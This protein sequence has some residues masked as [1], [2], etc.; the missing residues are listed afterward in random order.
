MSISAA[1]PADMPI[2]LARFY[3][4]FTA[5]V[6]VMPTV[7]EEGNKEENPTVVTPELLAAAMDRFQDEE[8]WY[9]YLHSL[10]VDTLE[11]SNLE[12]SLYDDE[13]L[14]PRAIQITLTKDEND[15]SMF[16]G[17]VSWRGAGC[18]S[19]HKMLEAAAWRID[20]RMSQYGCEDC[21]FFV[22]IQ[23][24]SIYKKRVRVQP[25]PRPVSA[26]SISGSE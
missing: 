20:D 12:E 26:S 18:L 7:D 23:T 16:H 5:G 13:S 9:E 11:D 15:P 2:K 25:V 1:A 19:Q 21:D 6:A 10:M 14:E 17:E 8:Q 24:T 3:L 22:S 4:T